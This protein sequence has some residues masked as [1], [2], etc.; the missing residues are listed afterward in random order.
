VGDWEP[1]AA[2][3]VLG[4]LGGVVGWLAIRALPRE[5]RKKAERFVVP[6][7]IVVAFAVGSALVGP[8]IKAWKVRKDLR[9]GGV[10]IYG[11]RPA[12]DAFADAMTALMT[13]PNF[14]ERLQSFRR[15]G[16][17]PTGLAELIHA[18]TGRLTTADLERLFDVKRALAHGSPE[19]CAGF[20]RGSFSSSVLNGGLRR[21]DEPRQLA[22]IEVSA[23]AATL[24]L[25]AVAPAEQLPIAMVDVAM[26]TI[27]ASLASDE[28]DLFSR[29]IAP[30]E[31][32]T[33]E[34]S[35]HAFNTLAKGVDLLAP[36]AREMILRATTNPEL[37]D[38]AEARPI[39]PPGR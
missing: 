7:S 31:P 36:E 26:D 18:G 37:V 22:W 12:A 10:Q 21:L 35:C 2:D 17:S 23:R 32:G 3:F 15:P 27:R 38:R 28:R 14:E 1:L 19:L 5:A 24:E 34:A 13:E 6:A 11:E 8:K 4:A 30:E 25:R 20:W 39:R 9:A 16:G 33:I 29:A